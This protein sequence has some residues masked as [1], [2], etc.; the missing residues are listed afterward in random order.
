MTSNLQYQLIRKKTDPMKSMDRNN[1]MKFMRKT[2]RN[3]KNNKEFLIKTTKMRNPLREVNSR[4]IMLHSLKHSR[5]KQLSN[6]ARENTGKQ[7]T[8]SFCG[9]KCR[10][11]KHR[12]RINEN[13]FWRS[14]REVAKMTGMEKTVKNDLAIN[15]DLAVPVLYSELE[16]SITFGT[17]MYNREPDESTDKETLHLFDLPILPTFNDF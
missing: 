7:N 4:R 5:S 17:F 10:H 14:L 1:P 13:Q 6:Q 3:K 15:L 8:E 11:K 9:I 12:Q 2:K 16:T